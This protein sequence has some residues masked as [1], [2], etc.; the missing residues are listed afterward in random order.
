MLDVDRVAYP[1]PHLAVDAAEGQVI[2]NVPERWDVI[3][4]KYPGNAKI[5]YIKRLVGRPGESI[6][7]L[8]G[9][10]YVGNGDDLSSFVVQTKPRKVQDALWRVVYDNDFYPRGA[11]RS[12]SDSPEWE[13]PWKQP[14][15]QTGWTTNNNARQF[16]FST[17][18]VNPRSLST[19]P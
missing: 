15:G 5:N 17:C 18:K 11:D 8:D 13:Q 7:V 3:V 10:V 1:Q 2:D 19:G 12:E 14:A 6:L 9:D 16:Q 4:F